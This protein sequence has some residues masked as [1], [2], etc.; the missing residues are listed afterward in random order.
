MPGLGASVAQQEHTKHLICNF[1]QDY[2]TSMVRVC[3]L[4]TNSIWSIHAAHECKITCVLPVVQKSRA[5]AAIDSMSGYASSNKDLVAVFGFV[6]TSTALGTSG[7]GKAGFA[8]P[9]DLPLGP[10]LSSAV[11]PS[12]TGS[13]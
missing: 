4:P 11:A 1:A 10:T 12:S 3:Y 9:F 7:S 13:F 5:V 8:S 6:A 2:L